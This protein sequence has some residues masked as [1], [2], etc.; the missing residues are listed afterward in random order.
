M[1]E[2]AVF[3][4]D[5]QE[6]VESFVVETQD[7]LEELYADLLRLEETTDP[8]LVERVFRAVHTVKGTSSFLGLDQLNTL[9]HH[10]EEVLNLQRKGN[11]SFHPELMDVLFAAFDRMSALLQ[12]VL[13][14]AIEPL[15]LDDLLSDLQALAESDPSG[16]GALGT[17]N[18]AERAVS[19]APRRRSSLSPTART[20]RRGGSVRIAVERLDD[21]MS[22]V[23]EL[24]TSRD[25]LANVV[26]DLER[27]YG[28]IPQVGCLNDNTARIESLT[29]EL[30][31]LV[32][33][34]RMV[35]VESVFN[36][37]PRVARDLGRSLNKDIQVACLGAET[38]LDRTFAEKI[39]EA[40]LHLIRNAID[41]GIEPRDERLRCGKEPEGTITLEAEHCDGMVEISVADDG[42]GL[43]PDTILRKAMAADRLTH[44]QAAELPEQ[45]VFDLIWEHGFS[46]TDV[47]NQLSGRGVGMDVVRTTV[48]HLGGSVD[49]Q[50]TRGE[51][52]RFTLRIPKTATVVRSLLVA[53]DGIAYALP[54]DAVSDVLTV[55]PHDVHKDAITVDGISVPLLRPGLREVSDARRA[56]PGEVVAAVL[57]SDSGNAALRVALLL[58]RLIGQ[59]DVFHT[60]AADDSLDAPLASTRTVLSDGQVVPVLDLQRIMAAS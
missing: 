5:M 28:P 17:P 48:L 58:D 46:T 11:I 7:I 49:V 25:A 21:L 1:S 57:R 32:E 27:A 53:I 56:A 16:D 13:G 29:T 60:T 52:T 47:A 39:G 51:G 55:P 41:H 34:T 15:P 33:T 18:M 26:T 42:R 23:D 2:H 22:I 14:G 6:V 45:A 38:Q 59:A 43:D 31:S 10:F 50:S 9:T 20:G 44:E 37:F 4:E 30:Q 35:A 24:T 36:K 8:S 54:Q 12:Q 40:L 19:E 3:S